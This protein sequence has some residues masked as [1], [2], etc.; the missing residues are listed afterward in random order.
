MF[1]TVSDYIKSEERE[2]R[3]RQPVKR[4]ERG[5]AGHFIGAANCLFRRNSLLERGEIRIVVSTVGNYRLDNKIEN[6][7]AFGRCH[8]TMAFR[9]EF[10]GQYWDT[11]V[12]C[13]F[14]LDCPWSLGI[15]ADDNE[16]NDMHE[17]AVAWV[18]AQMNEDKV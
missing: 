18:E 16:I 1:T 4:T 5:W 12:S 6:I 3:E 15:E 11:D 17:T 10:D 8:E 7:G 2:E 13:Q 14:H 9:A